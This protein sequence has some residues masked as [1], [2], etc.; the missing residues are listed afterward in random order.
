MPTVVGVGRQALAGGG[1]HSATGR[2]NPMA[3]LAGSVVDKGTG[4]QIEAKVQVLGSSGRFVHPS[5]A[6]LKV[7][8]GSPF[9]YSDG[10]F[11]VDVTRGPTRVLVERGTEYVPASASTRDSRAL[12]RERGVW[13]HGRRPTSQRWAI[14]VCFPGREGCDRH[15]ASCHPRALSMTAVQ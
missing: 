13:Q 2:Q 1:T 15:H 12:G 6:I 14:N 8:P 10:R 4:E 9:F 5:D 7:G 11:E 3:K